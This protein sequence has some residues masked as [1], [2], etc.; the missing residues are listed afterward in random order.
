VPLPTWRLCRQPDGRHPAR[1]GVPLAEGSQIHRCGLRAI[2]PARHRPWALATRRWR[3]SSSQHLLERRAA[4]DLDLCL[5][6]IS[7]PLLAAGF[8]ARDR[9]AERQTGA[10]SV[11]AMQANFHHLGEYS[12]LRR[13]PQ[14][15]HLFCLLGGNAGQSGPRAAV[16]LGTNLRGEPGD[17]LLVDS[18]SWRRGS[19]ASAEALQKHD[20]SRFSEVPPLLTAW[21]GGPLWRHCK[22]VHPSLSFRWELDALSPI[23][24]SYALEA[25]A[26][27]AVQGAAPARAFSMYRFRRY[28][29][30][31]LTQ[32]P[33]G[34]RLAR[35]LA[36]LPYGPDGPSPRPLHLFVARA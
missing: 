19:S 6:D 4:P 26:H 3:P 30:T 36:A 31:G 33:P 35:S 14:Q 7:Q 16:F 13:T 9:G 12:P 18:G 15:R 21:L 11:W 5:L 28:E 2:R 8:P 20:R 22:D 1:Q 32:W 10:V 27:G 34:T 25:L 29:P 23:P 17:L 24:G